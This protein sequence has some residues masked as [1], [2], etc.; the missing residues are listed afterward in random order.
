M[1]H[2]RLQ[3]LQHQLCQLEGTVCHECGTVFFPPRAICT[4]CKGTNLG[5]HYLSSS[6]TLY[7]FTGLLP[8]ADRG[9]SAAPRV[10]ALVQVEDGTMVFAQ[11]T[12]VTPQRLQI[13]MPVQM[14]IRKLTTKA[15]VSSAV[16][17]YKFRAD[18]EALASAHAVSAASH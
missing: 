1:E 16:Y 7:S 14:V 4:L 2:T 15:G 6:G 13:G 12:D 3:R 5:V 9:S 8:N 11:L 17:A 18:Y 10:F